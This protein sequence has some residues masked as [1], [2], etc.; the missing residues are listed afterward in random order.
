MQGLE[1]ARR[2]YEEFGRA[3][4]AE[5]F[6]DYEGRIAVGLAGSGSDCLGFD[7]DVSADHDSGAGFCLWLTDDDYENIGF[8]LAREYSKLP[9][10]F[11]GVPKGRVNSYG[12]S[13]FGVKSISGFYTPFTGRAGAPET[14]AEWLYTPEFSLAAAVSGEV[15]R[16]DLGEF[17]AVRERIKN[18]MPED[19]RLKKIAARVIAA[20]QSGQYNY[21]R[22]L[23]HGET[24]AAVLAAAEFVRN[25]AS[26]I[27]L[28]NRRYAPFYKWL[29]RGM[30][31]LGQL[32]H[33]ERE[34]SFI[35]T[36]GN[37][38][39]QTRAK[40]EAIEGVCAELA[41]YFR[42]CG[43]ASSWADFLEPYAYEIQNNIKDPE[44]R[45]M[46]IMEG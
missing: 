46:H 45:N 36:E 37:F 28:I 31:G 13:H 24:G 6:P 39:E 23:A 40:S 7:D 32:S 41:E 35:L 5:R 1:L 11:M 4:I 18:G 30:R 34:L 14:N 43:L 21:P 16:D 12:S 25:T 20:A 3:M 22:C 29:L 33:L 38:T 15:F 10:E 19:V 9:A 44:L 26:L 42:A 17:T 8:R 2:Y 27:Y